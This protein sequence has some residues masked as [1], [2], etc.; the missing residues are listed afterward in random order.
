MI[1]ATWNVKNEEAFLG[2]SIMSCKNIADEFIIVDHGS[3]DN[4]REIY[5][6]CVEL[7]PNKIFKWYDFDTK[8]PEPEAKNF[9]FNVASGEWVLWLD[10]DEVFPYGEADKVLGAIK[11]AETKGLV[12]IYLFMPE[13]VDDF[14]TTTKKLMIRQIGAAGQG[15][16]PR[17][18]SKDSKMY[19]DGNWRRSKVHI[20]GK[21]H[22]EM[23]HKMLHTQI[24]IY[25]Y[26]RLKTNKK[27]RREKII[28]HVQLLNERQS[29][30]W[31]V[32][33]V[34]N[35][36]N[37]YYKVARN[38]EKKYKFTGKQPEVFKEYNFCDLEKLAERSRK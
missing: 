38:L 32:E 31:C 23:Q 27:E 4:T 37:Y 14:Q 12:G 8:K 35:P 3:T 25:H 17:V 16:R 10:G 20:N 30:K 33:I 7:L 36:E 21:I 1:S 29:H 28:K 2:Y 13:F 5:N 34:D 19:V 9:K 22:Q 15:H 24:M 26:D 18:F 11:E 6:K